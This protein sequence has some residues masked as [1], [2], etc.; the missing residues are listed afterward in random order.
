MVSNRPFTRPVPMSDENQLIVPPSFI[1]L[2]IDPART[3]P[4]AP[5][6]HIAARYDLCE[7]MANLLVAPAQAMAAGNAFD[8]DGVLQRCHLGLR[9]DPET[10]SES[11]A[12]WVMQRLAE[13]LDW[14]PLTLPG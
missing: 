9:A 3:R 4:N 13:L 6:E 7:D 5:R 14:P 11:E 2:F 8:R 12:A 1:A 10:F